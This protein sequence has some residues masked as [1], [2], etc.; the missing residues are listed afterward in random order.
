M[1]SSNVMAQSSVG[2]PIDRRAW[3]M[4]SE[5]LR[6]M[7]FEDDSD[8]MPSELARA[9]FYYDAQCQE[10]VCFSCGL[11]KLS[12]L[13]ETEINP[14]YIHE[15]ENPDCEFISYECTENIPLQTFEE[16]GYRRKF[17]SQLLQGIVVC[18]RSKS[19]GYLYDSRPNLISTTSDRSTFSLTRSLS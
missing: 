11:R 9:G 10:T 2:G 5:F 7:S 18:K 16:E 15:L 12:S 17:F 4:R 3:L 6:L 14:R 19:V 8:L 1:A 13:W